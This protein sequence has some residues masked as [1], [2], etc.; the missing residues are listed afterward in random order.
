MLD[1][2]SCHRWY[3]GQCVGIQEN[4]LPSQWRCDEC[5]IRR[6]VELEQAKVPRRGRSSRKGDEQQ[7]PLAPDLIFRHVLANYLFQKAHEEPATAYSARFYMAQWAHTLAADAAS[8]ASTPATTEVDGVKKLLLG[9]LPDKATLATAPMLS[10]AG[11]S[12]VVRQVSIASCQRC[13]GAR[14][15]AN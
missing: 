6:Q 10:A 13:A 4:A 9:G 8:G 12:R 2:D 7:A 1:C 15:Y 14:S 5:Q 3:H 11:T